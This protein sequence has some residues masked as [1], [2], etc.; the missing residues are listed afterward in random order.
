M[1]YFRSCAIRFTFA[2]MTASALVLLLASATGCFRVPVRAAP[3]VQGAG[4]KG[5]V[6]D[7]ASIQPG[8]S[9]RQELLRDW[10]WCDAHV[11][12]D[13]LFIC[14]VER[15]TSRGITFVTYIPAEVSRNWHR[16][17]LF[18]EFDDRGI[19]SQVFFVPEDGLV[20]AMMEWLRRNPQ[21]PLDLR[22]PVDLRSSSFR[23]AKG[24][25]NLS[26]TH[27][28]V[29]DSVLLQQESI[30]LRSNQATAPELRLRPEQLGPFC[31]PAFVGHQC[32]R[33]HELSGSLTK[34]S[35]LY[36]DLDASEAMT[37]IRYL[38]QV[39]PSVTL[40]SR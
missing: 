4:G 1:Y 15:S 40:S 8:K 19:V 29:A 31:K 30:L 18:V 35:T 12:L 6:A 37:F 36:M 20:K 26:G 13:Q 33:V 14:Q 10:S 21:P 28:T 9:N 24:H 27:T 7:P 5:T 38:Q 23:L 34:Y 22:Q 2:I 11:N 16:Q 3:K 32:I 25:P 17:F 39:L